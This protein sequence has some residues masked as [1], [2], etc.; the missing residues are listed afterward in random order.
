[1]VLLAGIAT[2]ILIFS[3]IVAAAPTRDAKRLRLVSLWCAVPVLVMFAAVWLV[4]I[5]GMLSQAP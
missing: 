2:V 3:E 1:M 4:H 5:R